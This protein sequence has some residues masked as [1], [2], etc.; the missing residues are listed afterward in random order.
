MT[1]TTEPRTHQHRDLVYDAVL[2]G[3]GVALGDLARSDIGAALA[4]EL[5]KAIGRHIAGF[6]A[7]RGITYDVGTSPEDTAKA[8]IGVFVEHLDFARLEGTEPTEDRGVHGTWRDILG[9]SAYAELEKEYPDPFLSCPLNAVIRYELEKQGHTIKVHGSQSYPDRGVL[10]SWE[11]IR[12][13]TRFL[14]D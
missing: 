8:V 11:E 7:R 13:G 14:S 4:E 3:L 1:V 10:E 9:L 6:L 5:H 12:P 2:Y